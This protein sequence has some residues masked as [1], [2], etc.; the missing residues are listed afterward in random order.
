MKQLAQ[1][2]IFEFAQQAV[3]RGGQ[4][5]FSDLNIYWEIPKH[6][7]DV[8]A[9]GPEGKFTG[10]TYEDYLEESQRFA[11]ALFTVYGEGDAQSDGS[12]SP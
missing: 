5:I 3:A 10:N 9:I 6:F 4:S 8:P 2:L 7:M 11:N 1:I 12:Y